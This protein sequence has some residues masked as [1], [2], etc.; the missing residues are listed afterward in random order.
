MLSNWLA[1]Q[2]LEWFLGAH[3]GRAPL[4]RLDAAREAI[5]L[6]TWSTVDRLVAAGKLDTY[7]IKHDDWEGRKNIAKAFG[8]I[9]FGTGLLLLV[10]IVYAMVSRLMH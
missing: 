7:R 1:A 5:P 9:F 6:L 8:F 10:L 3:F 2:S 4:V